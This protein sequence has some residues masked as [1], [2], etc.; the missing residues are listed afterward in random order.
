[1]ACRSGITTL[2]THQICLALASAV[3]MMLMTLS[4]QGATPAERALAAE[5]RGKGWIAYC[6]RSDRK[7]WD[8]FVCRPDG[9]DV[10]NIT[11]TAD[12]NEAYPLFSR[13]GKRL[14][15]RRLER[16]ETISSNDH[17]TQGELVLADS[18]GST[19]AV[20]GSAGEYPWASWS[21]DCR[22]IACLT[23]KGIVFVDVATKK[24]VRTL[25]RQG[26]F[27]QMTWSPDG[28][29]LSGV[30]NNFDTGWSVARL[31]I[32]TGKA[33]A[34]QRVDCC[35]PDWFPDCRHVIFSKRPGKWT[36]LWMADAQGQASRVLFAEEGRHVYGGHMSPDGKYVLFTGN[37]REDG[38][39]ERDGAPMNLMRLADAP[40]VGGDASKLE[41]QVPRFNTGPLLGLPQGWEPNWTASELPA[42]KG[43]RE[44]NLLN[45]TRVPPQTISETDRY[46]CTPD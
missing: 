32:A 6:A 46:N 33:I 39:P 2:I 17:G 36:Q 30:A 9:S 45:S 23:I 10:R 18:D 8:L 7:D 14:M 40:I 12:F 41:R 19:P 15:Y 31:T 34:I 1:M 43:R 22:Q 38:D 16:N 20:F 3:G 5:V 44:K 13:D 26:F 4:G 28:L 11:N 37:V 35:T 25:P 42:G 29:S 24:V 27:Q 21:P